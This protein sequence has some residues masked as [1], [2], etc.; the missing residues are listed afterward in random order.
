MLHELGHCMELVE[1]GKFTRLKL[2]NFGYMSGYLKM[3]SV[4]REFLACVF[5]YLLEM[6]VKD[7]NPILQFPEA[8]GIKGSALDFYRQEHQRHNLTIS[9]LQAYK[10]F[11]DRVDAMTPK[12]D[13]T[14]R[15]LDIY[16]YDACQEEI[17]HLG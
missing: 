5:Q 10:D 6:R 17:G 11:Q 12:F 4:D 9:E 15:D 1:R 16:L 2:E 13:K 3:A 14:L 7:L 8:W